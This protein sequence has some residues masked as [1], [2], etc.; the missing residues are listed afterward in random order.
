MNSTLYAVYVA[1]MITIM[2]VTTPGVA[3]GGA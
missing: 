2:A 1:V 3:A